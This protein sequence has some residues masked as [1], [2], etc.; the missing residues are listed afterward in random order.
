MV[1]QKKPTIKLPFD[2]EFRITQRFG[3][4]LDWY[5]AIAGFPHNAIDYALPKGTPVLACD[6]G[7]ISYADNTPDSNGLGIN[8]THK[9]GLSQYWHFN[10]LI[11][12]LGRTVKKGEL[13][14]YS[15]SSGWATGPHLHFGIK[16]KGDAPSGMRGWSN[17]QEYFEKDVPEP[18]P[19]T[20]AG[21]HYLVRRGDSLWKI[22]KRFYGN[23]IHWP[24]IYKAN[25]DKIR[26]PNFIY[27]LQRLMIP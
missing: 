13:I 6:D 18:E 9:W 12:I 14:G 2:G 21:R 23:G 7:V 11:A 10:K 4:A 1:A 5:V 26:N 22:A 3:V 25:K 17:P 24:T 27:P 16:V 8:I 19:A 20:S 15:G